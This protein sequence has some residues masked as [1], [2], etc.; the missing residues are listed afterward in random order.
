MRETR[1]AVVDLQEGLLVVRIRHGVQQTL[2]DARA[3]IDACA[4]ESGGARPGLLLDLTQAEPLEPT[5]RHF[6]TGA[7]VHD[8]CSALALVV[9]AS[10]VGRIMGNI[11]LRVFNPRMPTK[12]FM[13]EAKALAWLR[14]RAAVAGRAAPSARP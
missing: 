13:T 14:S 2:D 11:Y 6:Y 5:V 9:E 4:Q 7:V 12:M 8:V 1:A 10:P 3:N